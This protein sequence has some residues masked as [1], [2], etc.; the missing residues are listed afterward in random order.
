VSERRPYPAVSANTAIWPA[1]QLSA[2]INFSEWP[3]FKH[4][5]K[6]RVPDRVFQRP[7]VTLAPDPADRMNQL[8]A[9]FLRGSFKTPV[10]S[11]LG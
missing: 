11:S 3:S 9:R 4:C 10:R 8:K 5:W 1:V 6:Q 7:L 2:F